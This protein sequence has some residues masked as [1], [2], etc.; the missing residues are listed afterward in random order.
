[1]PPRI[2][3]SQYHFER[4]TILLVFASH[5]YDSADYIRD[6]SDFRKIV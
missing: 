4:D 2:W 5:A 6:Y 3:G 1:M